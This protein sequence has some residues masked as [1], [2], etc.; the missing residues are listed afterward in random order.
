[1]NYINRSRMAAGLAV[2]LMVA[3]MAGCGVAEGSDDVITL[4]FAHFMPAHHTNATDGADLWMQEVEDRTGGRVQ[5]ESYPAGQL[6]SAQQ[7]VPSLRAGIVDVGIFTPAATAPADLPLSEI[8]QVPGFASS[9][10][11]V[12]AGAYQELLEGPLEE[13]W[14]EAGIQP[15]MSMVSGSYQVIM[16]GQPREELSDWRGKSVRS[17]G[18]AMDFFVQGLG[19]SPVSIPGPEIYEALDRGTVDSG[20]NSLESIPTYDFDEVTDAAT[21][22]LPLGAVPM[23]MGVSLKTYEELPA[24]VRTA[25]EEASE[26]V[27]DKN[28]DAL[29]DDLKESLERI[30]V[31][32]KMYELSDEDLAQY[33]PALEEAQQRWAAQREGGPEVL[34]AWGRALALAENRYGN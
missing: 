15:M 14:N 32:L 31:T 16:N 18:G 9:S 24:E 34:D 11:R 17:A 10:L 27:F 5:F 6:V 7:M 4:R 1:M 29:Q 22:N 8:P 3:P 25:M 2:M 26:V 30:S 23:A 21:L 12:M 20:V 28:Q 33:E 19:A 13:E